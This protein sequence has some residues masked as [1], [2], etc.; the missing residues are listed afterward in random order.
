VVEADLARSGRFTRST[1][2]ILSHAQ[3]TTSRWCSRTGASSRPRRWSSAVSAGAQGRWQVEF[4]LYDVYKEK[5]L[6]GYSYVVGGDRLRAV[7]HQIS[8]IIYEKL[9][10]DKAYSARVSPTSYARAPASASAT[11]WQIA[12]SDGYNPVT[13]LSSAE[14]LMSPA[15]SPDGTR[16]AYVSFEQRRPILYMQ[17]V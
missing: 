1:R 9:T 4:R 10:G 3:P 5:Q 16:L 14:P 6:A 17:N 7:A 13:V 12:D 2:S 11:S 8:D 15:W